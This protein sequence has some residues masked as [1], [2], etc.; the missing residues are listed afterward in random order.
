MN[1]NINHKAVII[2]AIVYQAVGFLWYQVIFS[3]PWQKAAGIS[4]AD[5]EKMG[6]SPH[7]L[8]LV[9]AFLFAYVFAYLQNSLNNKLSTGLFVILLL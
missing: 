8:A 5:I 2:A 4:T 7:I 3:T 1:N 9:G 6:T